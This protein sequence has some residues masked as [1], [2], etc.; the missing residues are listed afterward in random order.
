MCNSI[1]VGESGRKAPQ[2]S[3]SRTNSI[4]EWQL[5][6]CCKDTG[7][8]R[9]WRRLSSKCEGG[10]LCWIG[11]AKPSKAKQ[12]LAHFPAMLLSYQLQIQLGAC[13]FLHSVFCIGW[14]F[15]LI[16]SFLEAPSSCCYANFLLRV[17]SHGERD[18]VTNYVHSKL[19]SITPEAT[20]VHVAL[21]LDA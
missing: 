1:P 21:T 11:Q 5:W 18:S 14:H 20:K 8:G 3:G 13:T 6:V 19:P 12:N 17:I 16:G 10:M 4:D 2:N 9:E 7:A 15:L